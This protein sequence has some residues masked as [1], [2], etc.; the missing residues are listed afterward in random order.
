MLFLG[1]IDLLI[2]EEY[3]YIFPK[4]AFRFSISDLTNKSAWQARLHKSAN[5]HRA[6]R[7]HHRWD[8]CTTVANPAPCLCPQHQKGT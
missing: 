8:L 1:I 4:G 2:C 7:P 3:Y 6:V 5:G